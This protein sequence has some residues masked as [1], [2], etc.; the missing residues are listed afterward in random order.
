MKTVICDTRWDCLKLSEIALEVAV[1]QVEFDILIILARLVAANNR[2]QETKK[3][4]KSICTIER[5]ILQNYCGFITFLL[6]L[7]F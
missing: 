7:L 6:N 3:V 2:V 1:S 5:F 4:S